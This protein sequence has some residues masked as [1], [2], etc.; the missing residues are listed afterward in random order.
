MWKN[1]GFLYQYTIEILLRSS[2]SSLH[3]SSALPRQNF[4]GLFWSFIPSRLGAKRLQIFFSPKRPHHT[5]FQ[6]L[7]S[8]HFTLTNWVLTKKVKNQDV[9]ELLGLFENVARKLLVL[10]LW[11]FGQNVGYFAHFNLK[12]VALR[13]QMGNGAL[14]STWSKKSSNLL[15]NRG[16]QRNQGQDGYIFW[17]FK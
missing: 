13:S 15:R 9:Y 4:D 5:F 3:P 2:S 7:V 16:G 17:C 12:F 8:G 11:L 6:T 1:D 10:K 14:L